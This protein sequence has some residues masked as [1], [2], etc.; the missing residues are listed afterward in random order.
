MIAV[1]GDIHGCYNTFLQLYNDV[2]YR[3]PDIEVYS[4]G[5]LVDRGNYSFEV[6]EFF[7]QK[8]IKFTAGNH[9]L[10]FYY[11]ITHQGHPIGKPWIYNGS[12]ATLKS[13]DNNTLKMREHFTYITKAPLYMNLNE[14]FIS[15]AGISDYYR[16]KYK[17]GILDKLDDL[18]VLLHSELNSEHGVIWTRD[19]L[20]NIGKLQVVG[21]TIFPEVTHN[22]GNNAL[23]ID[24]SAYAGNKLSAVIVDDNKLVEILSVETFPE[25]I[26]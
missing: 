18:D 23:Y 16:K 2:T 12:E 21:H 19:E 1:I 14:C 3:Y 25:D 15:H 24:T 11:Y 26:E 20:M 9:D 13:Y 10:M 22:K 5:D 17:K 7:K 4:V 8:Q 6:V